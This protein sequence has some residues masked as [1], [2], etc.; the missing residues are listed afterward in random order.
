MYFKISIILLLT[1][2]MFVES[3]VT[4]NNSELLQRS[5]AN[6]RTRSAMATYF[7]ISVPQL[8]NLAATNNIPNLDHVSLEQFRTL[9][10]LVV[11][12]GWNTVENLTNANPHKI[13]PIQ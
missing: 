13:V 5:W 1:C 2:L 11:R 7:N 3:T 6:I 4:L 10:I 9:A 8:E 12:N